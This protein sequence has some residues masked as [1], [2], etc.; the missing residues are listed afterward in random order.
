MEGTASTRWKQQLNKNNKGSSLVT[1]LLISSI[2]AAIVTV[3]LAI[4]LLNVFMKKADNQGQRAFYDAESA[5]E[6]IRAGLAKEVSD[7]TSEA[8]IAT[9]SNYANWKDNERIDKFNDQ[10]SKIL[11]KKLTIKGTNVYKLPDTDEQVQTDSQSE[12]DPGEETTDKLI[13]YIKDKEYAERTQIVAELAEDGV[14]SLNVVNSGTS[15]GVVL[16]NVHVRYT[17]DAG[18]V[19]EIKT[20]IILGYPPIDFKDASSIEN[21]LTYGIIA[22]KAF[23][24]TGS[25]A[26]NVYGNAYLGS[27][28]GKIV[29][30]GDDNNENYDGA[31]DV[32]K[33]NNNVIRSGA[34]VNFYSNEGQETN[35]ISGGDLVL[36]KNSKINVNENVSFWTDSI[37]IN[38][39]EFDMDSGSS[40]IKNDI[41]LGNNAFTNLNGK[42]IMFGNPWVAQIPTYTHLKEVR[43]AAHDDMPSYSSSILLLGS[44]SGID[45]SKLR[46]MVIG[47]SA[48]I[49]TESHNGKTIEGNRIIDN[50]NVVSGQ[51]LMLKSDQR[52]YLVPAETVGVKSD[53]TEYKNGKSNP[54]TGSKFT[55]LEKEIREELNLGNDEQIPSR[56]YAN[57]TMLDAFAKAVWDQKHQT[58]DGVGA[59]IPPI[60]EEYKP[61][62][63][64]CYYATNNGGTIVYFFIDFQTFYDIGDK[65]YVPAEAQYNAWYKFYN[66]SSEA[67]MT[68]LRNN[69]RDV[70][71]TKGIKLPSN[72]NDTSRMYFTGDILTTESNDIIVQDMITR[73]DFTP[74]RYDEYARQSGYYQDAYYTLRKILSTRYELLATKEGAKNKELYDNLINNISGTKK[75]ESDSGEAAIVTS[76]GY[77]YDGEAAGEPT[78][79][80]IISEGD[81]VITKDFEGMIIA[82]GKIYVKPGIKITANAEKARK[83]LIAT[84]SNGDSAAEYV[85]DAD[86]YLGIDPSGDDEDEDDGDGLLTMKDYVTYKNWVRL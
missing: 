83:A 74:K 50:K 17:D 1:V 59:A 44:N 73:S 20:D 37:L 18:Y 10:F 61:Q 13:G 21:I 53:G 32:P 75:F 15:E 67:T 22:N 39:A 41:V 70:Y 79:N 86:K 5:L 80:V 52:A 47:G 26:V 35:V 29:S 49:D 14:T 25:A 78:I 7:A 85:I 45:L 71:A 56:A 76:N 33:S 12:G 28:M 16:K 48:Y 4:V 34:K 31:G 40:F 69:L 55:E 36:Q 60:P 72:V 58:V 3:I 82:K 81:V 64:V 66:E 57:M 11:T 23:D 84:D 65:Y 46:T 77:T 68:T 8:Y 27:E 51:S 2:V 19:S 63:R 62:V 24:P 9:L 54:M 6:E 42:L 30:D 38:E 43:D